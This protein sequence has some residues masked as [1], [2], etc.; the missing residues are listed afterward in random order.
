VEKGR[1]TERERERDVEQE[2]ASICTVFFK[3]DGKKNRDINLH[4]KLIIMEER[5]RI[6]YTG[7]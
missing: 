5:G 2:T 1:Q 4:V 7:G 3:S 6:H